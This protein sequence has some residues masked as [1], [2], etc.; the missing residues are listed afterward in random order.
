M[1]DKNFG[2]YVIKKLFSLIMKNDNET[3]VTD[4]Q[5]LITVVFTI[6]IKTPSNFLIHVTKK[7][8]ELF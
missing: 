1:L 7:V 4:N 5:R 8:L 6:L 3:E 2:V